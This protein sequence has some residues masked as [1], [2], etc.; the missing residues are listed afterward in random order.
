MGDFIDI[1]GASGTPYRFRRITPAELPA[2]AGN[3]V[4]AVGQPP[5]LK[6]IFCGSARSLARAAATVDESLKANRGAKLFVRLNVAR[7]VREA[8]HADIVAA[9]APEIEVADLD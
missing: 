9:V 5:R 1:P 3:L 7:A 8:E 2:T 4:V 6:V